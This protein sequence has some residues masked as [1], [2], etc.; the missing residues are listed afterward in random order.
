[1]FLLK[2]YF[3]TSKDHPSSVWEIEH[4]KWLQKRGIWD[5]ISVLG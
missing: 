3:W 2:G 5:C 1:M 4:L